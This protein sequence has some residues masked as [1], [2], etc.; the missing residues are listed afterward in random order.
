VRRRERLHHGLL[1]HATKLTGPMRRSR[2]DRIAG[3][4]AAALAAR[5]GRDVMLVRILFALAA[6]LTVGM[7]LYVVMWLLLPM[8]GD[9][10]S[11]AARALKDRRGIGQAIALAT[12][13]AAVFVVISLLGAG[14]A[15]GYAW[16]IVISAAGLV[17]IWRNASAEEQVLLRQEAEPL[18]A[19]TSQNRRKATVVRIAVALVLVIAG[20]SILLSGHVGVATLRPLGGL[21][22]VVAAIVILLG[23]WWLRV[24]RD[25][26]L[27]RQARARAEERTEIAARVHDSVLQT[28]ALIQRNADQ[29]SQVVKLARAQERELRSWLFEGRVPGETHEAGTVA[30]GIRLIQQDV[31]ERHGVPVEAITVGDCELDDQL[32]A[33][34]AAAREATVNAAKWSGAEVV[35]VFAEVEPGEVSVYVR[36]RGCG[37]DPAEVPLD[38]K[39]LAESVQA[40]MTRRGGTAVVRSVKDEGTEVTLRMPRTTGSQA[41][42]R[43]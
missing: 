17:L 22:L 34:L 38:R 1:R 19:L 37:F 23:P 5:F 24:A 30:E 15:N 36:D 8:E 18:M 9:D 43:A 31:E 7:P 16:G 41:V 14:W 32:R 12:L 39:G 11:I 3:G 40:R 2:E 28:L 10:G 4:V 29:P 33:L 27:E 20:L 35:S 21:I 6:L 26:M 42:S 25:L 13:L